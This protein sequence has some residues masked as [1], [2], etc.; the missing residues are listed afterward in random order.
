MFRD[1]AQAARAIRLLLAR[2]GVEELWSETGPTARAALLRYED[3]ATLPSGTRA[4]V[5][6]A[7][8]LWSIAPGGVPLGDVVRALDPE[9]CRCLCSLIV[10]YAEGED[11]VDAWIEDE[12]PPAAH[13][14]PAEGLPSITDGWPTLDLLSVR[15]VRRVLAR[16]DGSRSR[17]ASLLGVDR[18]TVGRLLSLSDRA[19]AGRSGGRRG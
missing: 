6:A 9:I 12:A 18:R 15:Y 7:F 11:A 19:A 4:L 2:L 16:V 3:D 14:G 5:L 17:A 8:S 13:A 10:A 1:D